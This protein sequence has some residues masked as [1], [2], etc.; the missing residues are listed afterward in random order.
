MPNHYGKAEGRRRLS[1]ALQPTPEST[2]PPALDPLAAAVGRRIED[3]GIGL[4]PGVMSQADIEAQDYA[5]RRQALSELAA[6]AEHDKAVRAQRKAELEA[7]RR[8]EA[9]ELE[10]KINRLG[11]ETIED[12][13]APEPPHIGLNSE[14]LLDRAAGQRHT[15]TANL[16]R[17]VFEKQGITPTSTST[18][19]DALR[20]AVEGHTQ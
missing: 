4:V 5:R 20:R 17:G 14:E 7:Q 2:E 9:E 13:R 6:Q 19:A 3:R 11:M 15:S 8:A 10:A 16:V 1:Q 12:Q 18:T